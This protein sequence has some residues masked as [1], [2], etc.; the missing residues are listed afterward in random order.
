MSGGKII[1]GPR[2]LIRQNSLMLDSAQ[3]PE[4]S[5]TRRGLRPTASLSREDSQAS[6]GVSGLEMEEEEPEDGKLKDPRSWLK[7]VGAYDQP[8]LLFDI[9]KKHFEK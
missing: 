1:S 3:A 9:T 5:N 6:I 4:L 8:R 7:V 2:G